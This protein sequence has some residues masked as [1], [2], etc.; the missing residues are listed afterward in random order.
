MS[1]LPLAC[2]GD[3]L[4][5]ADEP[6]EDLST[7]PDSPLNHKDA[8]RLFFASAI[9]RMKLSLPKAEWEALKKNADD[10]IYTEASLTFEGEDM[11]VVGLRFKGGYGSLF[12]CLDEQG[13]LL[14]PKLSM[15]LKFNE[16]VSGKR[17]YGMKRLNL[18]S[19]VRDDTKM[20]DK[21]SY[22]LYRDSGVIAP[23]SHWAVVE[24]NGESLGLYATVEQIDGRFTEQRWPDDGHGNLYK[25]VWPQYDGPEAYQDALKTNETVGTHER[26]LT[27]AAA[28]KDAS[29]EEA[30]DALD[31]FSDTDQL[32]AYMA[33]QDATANWDGITAWYCSEYGCSNHN[34]YWYVQSSGDLILIPWDLDS[35]LNPAAQLGHVPHWTVVPDDCDQRYDAFGII[36]VAAPGCNPFFQ[37]L[38]SDYDRYATKV[39]ELIDG[40]FAI[41]KVSADIDRYTEL[42]RDAVGDDPTMQGISGWEENVARMKADLTFLHERL[43]AL[44]DREPLTPF[45][46]LPGAVMDFESVGGLSLTL[47]SLLY[48]APNTSAQHL[49]NSISPSAGANDLRLEYIFR[50]EPT[51][52]WNQWIALN[53]LMEGGVQDLSSFSGLRFDIVAEGPREV[54]VDLD[55][56]L[57]SGRNEGIRPGWLIYVTEEVQ[58]ISLDL[59]DLAVPDWAVDPGDDLA[60][61]LQTVSGLILQPQAAGRDSSGLLGADVED[62]GFI[63]I[64]NIEFF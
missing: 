43:L 21:I 18:H 56:A 24:V 6:N 55:S 5:D 36:E 9:P 2:R 17:F 30:L 31:E 53:L 29:P 4:S 23:R 63:Q 54:R 19:M 15:K 52:T 40:P 28:L 38:A 3:N 51:G 26:M 61:I 58:T 13:N 20:H 7:D 11:G 1:V 49:I 25:E 34:F 35:T 46:I 16:Y 33:V 8:D 37:G 45:G 41:S 62:T 44:R 48:S 12:A 60:A 14:C 42:L 10:E 47:G 64:D 32:Y 50:D 59:A 22:G 57:E 39:Q 27:F